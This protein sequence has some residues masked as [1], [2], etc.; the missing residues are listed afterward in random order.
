MFKGRNLKKQTGSRDYENLLI[1]H[2]L[3][4]EL[5]THPPNS[6]YVASSDCYLF[7]DPNGHSR[8]KYLE[9]EAYFEINSSKRKV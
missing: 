5:L 7:A 8:Q 6:P 4:F 1:H 2:E 3:H 9:T